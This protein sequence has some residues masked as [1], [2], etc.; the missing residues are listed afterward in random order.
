M[1][2]AASMSVRFRPVAG[3]VL[4]VG[5]V[6]VLAVISLLIGVADMPLGDLIS[7]DGSAQAIQ[8]LLVSRI[9]RTLALVLSGM[10][11]GVAALIMQMLFRNRFVEPTTTGMVEA[12]SL[13]LLVVA[14]LAPGL[15]IF[16]KMVVASGFA[17]AAT[18]MFLRLVSKIPAGSSLIVPLLGLM[19]GGVINAVTT[20]F[21]YR[22]DLLQ[23]LATWINGDFSGVLR[24]RYEL[25]WV[26]GGLAVLSY[27]AAD[28]FTV[29]GL[30]QS[31][32]RNLGLNYGRILAFGLVIVSMVSASAVVT[33]GT[34][35]FLGLIV[36]NVVSLTVGDNLRRALPWVALSGAGFLLACDIVGRV[37][38]FPYEIPVGTVAGVFGS[39]IFLYLLLRRRARFG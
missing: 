7:G 4:A 17:L 2:A 34:V 27:L 8:L 39:G 31:F 36:A 16:Y 13:G 26:A 1:Q 14:L 33:A 12:A 23:S 3:L 30:G 22:Y 29:A 37:L 25:L 5:C 21:A 24:G 19:F 28:R 20:F 32:T 18:F 38:R 9:P 11:M 35:P 10:S 6:A 15:P